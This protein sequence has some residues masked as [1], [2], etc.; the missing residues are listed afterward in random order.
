MARSGEIGVLVAAALLNVGGAST[1][2]GGIVIEACLE[3]TE[4][5]VCHSDGSCDSG[6]TCRSN[7]CVYASGDDSGSGGARTSRPLGSGGA[8]AN[9]PIGLGGA[10]ANQPVGLG[11]SAASHCLPGRREACVGPNNCPGTHT[12]VPDGSGFGPCACANPTVCSPGQAQ[13]CVAPSGCVGVQIC[14]ADGSGFGPCACTN[15]IVCSPGQAQSCLGPSGCVGVQ[16]CLPDGSGFGS[17]ACP[18]SG[19]GGSGTG[20]AGGTGGAVIQVCAPN[21]LTP[22]YGPANCLGS[23]R[24]LP[25]GSGYTSCD[26]G[27]GGGT[28]VSSSL[29]PRDGYIQGGGVD[30]RIW[31]AWYTFG[32]LNSVFSPPEGEPVLAQDDRIC[33]SGTVAQVIGGDYATYY[34]AMIGFDL[35]G[36]PPDMSTCDQWMPPEYCSWAPESQHTITECGIALNVISFDI[37]GMLPSTELRLVFKERDRVENPYLV[38]ASSGPFRGNP[39]D[40]TLGYDSSAPPLNLPAVEAIHFHVASM[41]SGPVPFDFCISNLQIQ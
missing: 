6:L 32:G 14:L 25:D 24:C 41:E 40:A 5:C 15:P 20:G 22:C 9:Q 34:G 17:C 36:M 35:C 16:I 2:C 27:T 18:V 11:G 4:A 8:G 21:T 19:T 28:S 1:G 12:C 30:G 31:G 33:F 10:G 39:T 13:S 38:V 26:C 7:L 3:G 37:T 23:Q 29:L